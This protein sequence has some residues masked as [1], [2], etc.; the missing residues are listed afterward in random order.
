V[1]TFGAKKGGVDDLKKSQS[2]AKRNG[3]IL[4]FRILHFSG[5]SPDR[6]RRFFPPAFSLCA[7]SLLENAKNGL[8]TALQAINVKRYGN[9]Y[10]GRST[11][12]Y[13]LKS[14]VF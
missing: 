14:G 7:T 8:K 13:T 12:R 3:A 2:G 1:G 5:H 6:R 10:S 4:T 11:G 9:A